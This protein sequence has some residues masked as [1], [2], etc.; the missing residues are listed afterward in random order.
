MRFLEK[1]GEF[2]LVSNKEDDPWPDL[3]KEFEVGREIEGKIVKILDKGI[4]LELDHSIEGI[5]PMEKD[6]KE[7]GSIIR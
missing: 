5:V 2:L 7:I 4:I 6:L 3:I 1:T